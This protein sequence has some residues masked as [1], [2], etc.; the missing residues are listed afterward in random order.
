LK[1]SKEYQELQNKK[2]RENAD[3]TNDLNNQLNDLAK[4][5]NE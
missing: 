2:L 4:E 3:Y 1:E 5:R